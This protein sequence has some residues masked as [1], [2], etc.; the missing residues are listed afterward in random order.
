MNDKS[1][2]L[3]VDD[4]PTN[5]AILIET[6]Q[7]SYHLIVAKNGQEALDRAA[8]EGCPDLILM[9]VEMPVMNG[10]D[11]CKAM[12]E[13]PKLK[14]VPVIFITVLSAE[15]DE[16]YGFE[17]GAVDYITKPFS[18]SL[19]QARVHT[20]LEL[21]KHRDHLEA[22]AKERMQQL[23]HSERLATLGSLSAGIVHEINNPLQY[24]SL[25]AELLQRK[26]DLFY[27]VLMD[28]TDGK[29]VEIERMMDFLKES[30]TCISSMTEGVDRVN[31]I[32]QSMKNFSRRDVEEKSNCSIVE[33]IE[34]SLK[35]C[36]NEL[37]YGVNVQL[38]IAEDL[39]TFAGLGRQVEQVF[40]NLFHNAAQAI[41]INR[42]YEKGT[43][44]VVVESIEGQIRV[45]IE[46]NGPG[47]PEDKLDDI[48]EPFFTTKPADEGTGLGL[49]VSKGIIHDHLGHIRVENREEGGAR[50][51]VELPASSE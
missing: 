15:E 28:Y 48:W 38:D 10:Y 11:A 39:P 29:P 43:M 6:L 51:T 21:K 49:A 34:D 12:K 42:G 14:N 24:I 8:G 20:H 37:K 9:D 47:I 30:Q 35:L 33:C 44:R 23:I 4:E 46:D 5:L 13:D 26:F 31:G 16:A 41:E 32:M 45:T 19:V 3:L 18:P 22:L 7:D 1:T 27:P 50:F 36:E 40:I 17:L 25:S 2:I